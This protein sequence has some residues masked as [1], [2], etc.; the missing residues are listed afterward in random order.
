[1]F[2][3]GASGFIF[4][5][6]L[7]TVATFVLG[8]S[9]EQFS[10]TISLM[11]L[12]MGLAGFLQ[13]KIS[14]K[15]LVEKFLLVEV[16]LAILGGFAPI[17]VYAAYAAMD[18]HF[19]LV[20]YFFV[21]SIGFLI[22]LEIPLVLRLN[23]H[24]LPQLKSNIASV[25]STDYLG[26]FIGALIWVYVLLRHFPL[27]E[28]S[29]L[30]AGI[31]FTVALV[32]YSYFS[33]HRIASRGA[34]PAAAIGLTAISLIY[35]YSENRSWNQLLEQRFYSEPIAYSTTT[36]YQHIVLTA[37]TDPMDYRLYIN[38]NLQFSS[39]DE[40]IYHELLVH[41]AMAL[42]ESRR[43]VLILGGGDGLA[44]REVL[45][46][47]E[48]REITLVDIDPGMI[49]FAAN[50]DVMTELN[51][52]AFADA[53]VSAEAFLETPSDLQRRPVYE[54]ATGVGIDPE[55]TLDQ[56]ALVYVYT[57]DADK[58]LE[59][60]H[61]YFDV[62]LID[63]PDP[64]SVELVKLY[65]REFYLKVN[66]LLAH[67]GILAVQS[68]SPYHAKE[69]FLCILRT[70][71]SAGYDAIPYHDNVPSFGD[72]GWIMAWNSGESMEDVLLK[73]AKVKRF[74]IGEDSLQ[75]LTP[76]RLHA[77]LSFGKNELVTGN[78]E[79][80]SLMSPTLLRFYLTES[81]QR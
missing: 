61:G 67:G 66:R 44:L 52:G 26:A 77:S 62:I 37:K 11:M 57:V 53:R 49:E 21:L 5:C 50:H 12:M 10:V 23:R 69:S 27:T 72:W 75:Y 14:D 16:G 8:N 18:T 80:N 51:G 48:T 6:I 58:V 60:L 20:Q 70:I 33:Y 74:N 4:E 79:V 7:S 45:K 13:R 73:I 59:R 55:D 3:T 34:I 78:T 54:Y 31:S 19:I 71:Q 30:V 2:L 63:L 36:Q 42:A 39:I 28:I 9:I 22:G 29:F 65:S 24:F 40:H 35:G 17:A 56:A 32:T 81:W 15:R 38:G 43:R 1:M 25:F 76:Q 46:Y 41:P 68:T 64:N 47:A